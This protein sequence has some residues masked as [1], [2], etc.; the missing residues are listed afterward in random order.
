VPKTTQK[1]EVL[2]PMGFDA[3]VSRVEAAL[4]VPGIAIELHD[5]AGGLF[6]ARTGQT[7]KGYGEKLR[8]TLV[9]EHPVRVTLESRPRMNILG[10]K[11]DC[12]K[13]WENVEAIQTRLLHDSAGAMPPMPAAR[14]CAAQPPK[15]LEAGAW[16]RLLS[17]LLVYGFALYGIVRRAIDISDSSQQAA[18]LM[19]STLPL[20]GAAFELWAYGKF[21]RMVQAGERVNEQEAIEA[22]LSNGFPVLF[23]LGLLM[24]PQLPLWAMENLIAIA[25]A[26]VFGYL[27]ISRTLE[28]SREQ[29]QR[30]AVAKQREKAE[31][32]RQLAEAKLAALSAQIE[33][34]FLFNTL[35]SI[36]YLTR[37][38]ADKAHTMVSD[39]IRYLRLALPRMKQS[40]ARLDDELQLVEAYLSIMQIRMGARL[41]FKIESPGLLA[42]RQIPTMVLITLVENAI[43]HGL[44]RQADGGVI[45]VGVGAEAG[46]LI[47][48]VAD[49]GGGFSTAASGTGIG[50]ANVRERLRTLYGQHGQLELAPNHPSGVRATVTIPME[51]L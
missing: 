36:Q 29:A 5:P 38:D 31:L 12:G 11:V 22:M 9:G 19:L 25:F 14:M 20:A 43:K 8:V 3:A 49:T 2:L 26:G 16:E 30:E 7:W 40:T 37:N 27:G 6:L 4:L 23:V 35:A 18:A 51:N 10:L 47:L 28:R 41:R 13:N 33:P 48:T 24:R 39:L 50:L 32:Q 44:E 1:R 15:F 45:E 34:H 21:R 42:D 46:H 17:A